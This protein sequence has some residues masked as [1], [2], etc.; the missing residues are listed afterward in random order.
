MSKHT[1]KLEHKRV[2]FYDTN[3]GESQFDVLFKSQSSEYILYDC[4]K[5]NGCEHCDVL[6]DDDGSG[7]LCNDA[8]STAPVGCFGTVHTLYWK[9][10]TQ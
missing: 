4:R 9:R 1:A 2:D 6:K 3:Q 7:E 8:K 10:K 5:G